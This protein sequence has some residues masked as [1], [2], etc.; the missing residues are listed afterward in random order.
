MAAKVLLEV[1]SS[2]SQGKSDVAVTS[3]VSTVPVHRGKG[4]SF[5]RFLTVESLNDGRNYD[6]L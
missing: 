3:G 4:N 6:S 2:V 1:M 5:T